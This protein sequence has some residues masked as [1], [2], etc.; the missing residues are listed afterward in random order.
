MGGTYLQNADNRNKLRKDAKINSRMEIL[1][2]QQILVKLDDG[3][4][5]I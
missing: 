3:S 4:K 2:W 5:M 1:S